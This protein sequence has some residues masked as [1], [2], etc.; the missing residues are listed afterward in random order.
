[1]IGRSVAGH[2]KHED[3]QIAEAQP[4][5]IIDKAIEL[6][7]ITRKVLTLIEDLPEYLLHSLDLTTDRNFAA[8][9]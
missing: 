2:V 6:G 3:F 8:Y 7:A 4:L 1:M 5:S 9:L